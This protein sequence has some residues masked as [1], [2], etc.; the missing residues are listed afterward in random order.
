M[1][2]DTVEPAT[3]TSK[4]TIDDDETES[5]SV[6]ALYKKMFAQESAHIY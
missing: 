5:E 4:E 6:A 3:G 1:R 2:A